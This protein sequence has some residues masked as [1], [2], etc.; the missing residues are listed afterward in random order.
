MATISSRHT[1]RVWSG[2][3]SGRSTFSIVYRYLEECNKL[4]MF[5]YIKVGENSGSIPDLWHQ[6]LEMGTRLESIHDS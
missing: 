5:V 4:L 6:V 1:S 2:T 3:D